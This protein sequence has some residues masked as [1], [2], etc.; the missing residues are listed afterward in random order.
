MLKIKSFGSGSKGNGY[1]INDGHSQLLIEC[2]VSFKTIQRE[3]DF[4]FS[5]VAGCLISHEHRDHCK[6]VKQL[7]DLTSVDVYTTRGTADGLFSDDVLKLVQSDYYRF[8]TLKYKETESIGTWRVTPFKTE[9]DAS[10]PCGFLIDN[11][12]GDRLVFVTDSYYVRYQFPNV[13]HMMIEANYS[14]DIIDKELV[15]GFGRKH[16]TRLMESHFDFKNTLEF[17]KTNKSHKLQEIWLLHLSDSNSDEAL[18][19]KETQKLTGVPVYIA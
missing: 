12:A 18:F 11:T 19:K 1:L 4:D 16:K 13:T 8:R 2:G 9:H 17:I 7:L 15:S 3:M 6:S 5:R 14:K 10:E